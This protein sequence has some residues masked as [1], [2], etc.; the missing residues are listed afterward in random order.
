[1]K[2]SVYIEGTGVEYGPEVQYIDAE[3]RFEQVRDKTDKY[4]FG[5]LEVQAARGAK[6]SECSKSV[7]IR[8]ISL[9]FK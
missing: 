8:Q 1:M 6:N 3:E 5:L 2:C 4:S 7:C 9:K